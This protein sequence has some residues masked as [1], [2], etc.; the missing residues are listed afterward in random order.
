MVKIR[1][2]WPIENNQ[3]YLDYHDNEWG[4]PQHN[5]ITLFEFLVLEGAQSG[6][7][8][9]TILNKRENYR[10]AFD[11][12]DFEKIARYD[13]KKVD[14]LLQNA[15]IVRNKLKIA[16]A[17]RNAKVFIEIRKEFET[18]D[19]YL[20]GYVDGKPIKN[21]F[22]TLKDYPTKTELSDKISS[23]LKKRG[24]NFVGSTIIY[25]F[26]QAI[27]VVNDHQVKCFKYN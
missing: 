1:C 22:K 14:E 6:L 25:A 13:Q 17:I 12:L 15:G 23:D 5:D 19:K 4:V 21:N 24:M 10:K 8:W 26:L 27:G 9:S 2:D 11:N 3:L 18:F 16:S 20:W 7:S